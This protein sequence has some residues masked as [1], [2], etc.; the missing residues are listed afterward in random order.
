MANTPPKRE[1]AWAAANLHLKHT[2]T[3]NFALC[4]LCVLK[5]GQPVVHSHRPRIPLDDLKHIITLRQCA[6]VPQHKGM[7]DPQHARKGAAVGRD[8]ELGSD[9]QTGLYGGQCGVPCLR[10]SDKGKKTVGA[11][12]LFAH[13]ASRL[14]K[15]TM[16]DFE[17][18][19]SL[20]S[21]ALP[22]GTST[23]SS[24]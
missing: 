16:I 11:D 5:H 9:E 12:S 20:C 18:G 17:V 1:S 14:R 8:P 19:V 22:S 4:A 6:E 23:F 3:F 21:P 13:A 10:R 7:R 2:A 15:E 24:G